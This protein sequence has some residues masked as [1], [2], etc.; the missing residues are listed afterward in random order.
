MK[1]RNSILDRW[2]K[3]LGRD[4]SRPAILD[5]AGQVLRTYG[6]IEKEAAEWDIELARLTSGTVLAIQV[7]NH[8]AWPALF[9]AALRRELTTL[10]L[11]ASITESE[12]TAALKLSR[13]AAL[14]VIDHDDS[15]QRLFE[16]SI[17][18][19]FGQRLVK[20]TV[21]D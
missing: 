16:Q 17:V 20:L 14:L 10:P 15:I 11:E 7:G 19:H 3:T 13:A 6:D 12:R 4:A 1:S 5:S 18:A 2:A 21:R 9:L 8:P